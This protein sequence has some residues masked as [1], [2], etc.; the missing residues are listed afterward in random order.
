[1]RPHDPFRRIVAVGQTID[2]SQVVVTVPLPLAVDERGGNGPGLDHARPR[3]GMGGQPVG[4]AARARGI[5]PRQ[6]FEEARHAL[7]IPARLRGVLH[8][9]AIRF[10]FVVPSVLEEPRAQ[11]G[12][13]QVAEGPQARYENARQQHADAAARRARV[14]LRRVPRRD[15]PHFMAKHASQLRFIAEVREQPARDVDVAARQGERVHGGHID[16]GEGPRQCGTMRHAGDALAD[17]AHVALQLV[18][19]VDA[20]LAA[21][22]AVAL[23]PQGNLFGLAD[24]RHLAAAGHGI[25]RAGTRQ[26]RGQQ[27]HQHAAAGRHGSSGWAWHRVNLR[28]LGVQLPY[29][30]PPT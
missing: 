14:L 18:I 11:A 3:I 21:N 5:K 19:G 7:R 8:A 10:E 1:M 25:G 27:R 28:E 16:D 29:H 12:G 13:G 15:V 23:T 30:E 24:E 20:H 9:Q 17:A 22:L 4:H 26:R 6:R 2:A